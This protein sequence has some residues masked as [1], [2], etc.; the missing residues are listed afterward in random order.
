M[1][2]FIAVIALLLG[3]IACDDISDNVVDP[4]LGKVNLLDITG[5]GILVR[6]AEDVPLKVVARFDNSES[7][8]AVWFN[9]TSKDG[10]I[11][12]T[13]NQPMTDD[14]SSQNGD[15]TRDDLRFTGT[16]MLTDEY[17]SDNYSIE[18]F[19]ELNDGIIQKVG[20]KSLS[21]DSGQEN[22]APVISDLSAPDSVVIEDPKSIFRLSIK[23]SD[24][25]GQNDISSVYFITTRPDGT[26]NNVK[27]QLFDSGN[28]QDHG[29]EEANDGIYSVIV[30]VTPQNAKGTYTFEFESEDRRG[31]KSNIIQHKIVL[32]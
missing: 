2:F 11:S 27:I 31:A 18:V 16:V 30:E 24:S 9:V 23:A 6:L 7:I 1:R 8:K 25:N 15:D 26:S 10:T 5:P 21:Y 3:L 22:V 19:T 17:P 32:L 14:G 20:F 12:I 28:F 4:S 13:Q 29:D